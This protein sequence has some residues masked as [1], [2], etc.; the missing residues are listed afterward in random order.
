M[1]Q[2]RLAT[3]ARVTRLGTGSIQVAL[4]PAQQTR[5]TDNPHNR[6]LLDCLARPEIGDIDPQDRALGQLIRHQLVITISELKA[7]ERRRR[8]TRLYI[9]GFEPSPEQLDSIGVRRTQEPE[10]ATVALLLGNQVHLAG[11]FATAGLPHLVADF[12]GG[13]PRLGPFVAPGQTPCLDCLV[14]QGH[15][16]IGTGD[17]TD[18]EPNPALL[19]LGAHFL[20]RDLDTWLDGHTPWTWCRTILLGV[21]PEHSQF[22]TW[23]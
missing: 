2:F 11:D 19:P 8:K 12:P 20:F 10:Q 23:L 17:L 6:H 3:G 13:T 1:H 5:I 9:A 22:R 16:P 7:R 18:Y 4:N 14:L 21:N 15:D